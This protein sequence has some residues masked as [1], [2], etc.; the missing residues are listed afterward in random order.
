MSANSSDGGADDLAGGGGVA[1]LAAADLLPPAPP[2]VYVSGNS[3]TIS[4]FRLDL[5]TGALTPIGT[6]TSTGQTSYLAIDPVRGHLFAVDEQ[7]SKVEAFTIDAGTGALT[8]V[9]TDR[10]SG[11]SGPAHLSVDATGKWVLTANYGSGDVAVLAV[12]TDGSLG[13]PTALMTAPGAM[14]HQILLD[15][16]NQFAWVPCLGSNHIAQFK[17]NAVTGALDAN[18]PVNVP[19]ATGPRHVALHP[20]GKLAF[21]IEEKDGF[22]SNYSVDAAGSLTTVGQRLSTRATPTP[23]GTNTGA[24]VQVHPS[25]KFL[26]GSNRGDDDVVLY[27]LATNGTMTYVANKK[28]GGQTPRHFSI[29][30]TGKWLLVANQGSNDVRVFAIASDGTLTETGTPKPV[31]APTFVGSVTF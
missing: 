29:D 21:M 22:M 24:E 13:A 5:A 9:G 27:T 7:N 1:D 30:A 25:G 28:T 18:V 12:A 10:G 14:A 16:T 19:T 20:S 4:R 8:H 6:T 3:S 11:G 17:L 15:A 31:T 23:A 2:W 26:Y